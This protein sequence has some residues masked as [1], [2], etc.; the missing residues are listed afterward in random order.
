MACQKHIFSFGF[1]GA[2]ALGF[3]ACT[4]TLASFSIYM[5]AERSLAI[6]VAMAV[7][8]VFM[9]LVSH[10]FVANRHNTVH[11]WAEYS[12]PRVMLLIVLLV[13]E[14]L[15]LSDLVIT[16]LP[17]GVLKDAEGKTVLTGTSHAIFVLVLIVSG[18]LVDKILRYC[19]HTPKYDPTE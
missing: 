18:Y 8:A 3:A 15:S 9:L 5:G 2:T 14:T 10:A 11:P 6:Q 4:H 19:L 7:S 12:F 13:C 17:L 1:F 16:S